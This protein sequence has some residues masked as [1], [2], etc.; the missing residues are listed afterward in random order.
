MHFISPAATVPD[1]QREEQ[2]EA[3]MRLKEKQRASEETW[4]DRFTQDPRTAP[5]SQ[6]P[7]NAPVSYQP[8]ST[9]QDN[10]TGRISSA[11]QPAVND[12]ADESK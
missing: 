4:A 8:A 2:R 3:R 9:Y 7:H 10:Q 1:K 5:V 6:S 12:L 11:P